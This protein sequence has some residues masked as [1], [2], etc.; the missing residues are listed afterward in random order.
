[1]K[2]SLLYVIP[3][4]SIALFSLR[5]AE[6]LRSE[7]IRAADDERVAAVMAGDRARLT[8]I[9]SDDLRY[10]HSTGAVDTK[11]TYIEALATGSTKYLAWSYD[12]RNFTFPAPGIALMTGSAHLKIGKADGASDVV[13]SF[14]GVWRE[15]MGRWR[16]LSWQ[17]CKL[18][19]PGAAPK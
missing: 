5:A 18:A 15:E 14:L 12:E 9:F 4:F 16:F 8:A 10:A 17:S 6:D 1:M 13:L 19:D 2:A 11:A 7:K 3:F